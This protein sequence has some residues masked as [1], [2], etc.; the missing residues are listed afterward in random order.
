MRK[1]C[2]CA[3]LLYSPERTVVIEI[4]RFGEKKLDLLRRFRPFR[5][6]TPSHDHLG[7]IFGTL[8]AGAFR[9]CFVLASVP[10]SGRSPAPS[11]YAQEWQACRFAASR[12]LSARRNHASAHCRDAVQGAGRDATL[13]ALIEATGW[14]PH[15]TRA[16]LTGLRKK[17][18]VIERLGGEGKGPSAYS[19]VPAMKVAA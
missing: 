2:C 8:D 12:R 16:A 1:F 9:R 10:P 19:V 13:D 5:G 7:D 14:L 15:T 11:T 3:C 6:G 17:G 4:A 18:Y